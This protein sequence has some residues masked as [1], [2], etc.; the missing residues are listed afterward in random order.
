MIDKIFEEYKNQERKTL[1]NMAKQFG[2]NVKEILSPNVNHDLIVILNSVNLLDGEID[3]SKIIEE[4]YE[5]TIKEGILLGIGFGKTHMIKKIIEIPL[6]ES[7]ILEM[8]LDEYY[9]I[10][11]KLDEKA[12]DFEKTCENGMKRLKV[13]A[14]G[15]PSD[16]EN[17]RNAVA[18]ITRI[19][20]NNHKELKSIL[21]EEFLDDFNINRKKSKFTLNKKIKIDS[22]NLKPQLRSRFFMEMTGKYKIKKIIEEYFEFL[23][24]MGLDIGIRVGLRLVIEDIQKKVMPFELL[25]N[26]SETETMMYIQQEHSDYIYKKQKVK[27]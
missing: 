16:L 9:E 3:S 2:I 15:N 19:I 5:K 20:D 4:F 13:S 6:I 21:F 11:P 22:E 7:E 1:I 27:T 25:K 10:F 23:I 26:L 8:E 12:Y 14:N 24:D 18:H 17:E